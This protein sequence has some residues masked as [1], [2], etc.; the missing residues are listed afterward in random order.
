[1]KMSCFASFIPVVIGGHQNTR[2]QQ[3]GMQCTNYGSSRTCGGMHGV[4]VGDW[5]YL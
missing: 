2:T 4:H 3:G 1:M 5:R